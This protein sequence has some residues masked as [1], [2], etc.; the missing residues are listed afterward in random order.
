[1]QDQTVKAYFDQGI[2]GALALLVLFFLI[3]L[4]RKAPELVDAWH[5]MTNALDRQNEVTA[6]NSA[7]INE[8]MVVHRKWEQDMV[9][10]RED[11][12]QSTEEHKKVNET[13]KTLTAE[14]AELRQAVTEAATKDDVDV[15]TSKIDAIDSQIAVLNEL[16][17]QTL[18]FLLEGQS[19]NV[20][21]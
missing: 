2:T 8:S 21:K 13:I 12:K 7:F 3:L 18:P 17:G 9:F 15:I 19:T 6:Q 4:V 20:E 16:L 10:L 14:V 5:K 1:M 11:R